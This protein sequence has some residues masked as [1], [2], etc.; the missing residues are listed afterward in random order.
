MN[1]SSPADSRR[2]R[3]CP[4][5][6]QNGSSVAYYGYRYYD[7]QTGRWPSRDP[8]NEVGGPWWFEKLAEIDQSIAEMKKRLAVAA[9]S[10]VRM[11]D[12]D[13]KE[14]LRYSIKKAAEDL[15][16]AEPLLRRQASWNFDILDYVFLDNS[17]LGAVDHLGLYRS[18]CWIPCCKST[19]PFVGTK[20]CPCEVFSPF[21]IGGQPFEIPYWIY[22]SSCSF[23]R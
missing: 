6:R 7:P 9:T 20:P 16:V 21:S 13:L 23:C 8:K 17:S 3:I 12:A 5:M 22:Y 18:T 2:A 15:E 4:K 11:H 19:S 10:L 1:C 14:A